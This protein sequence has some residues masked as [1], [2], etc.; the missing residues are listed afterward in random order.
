MKEILSWLLLAAVVSENAAAPAGLLRTRVAE[1]ETSNEELQASFA[2]LQ[3]NNEELQASFGELQASFGE[4]QGSF[5]ALSLQGQSLFIQ[6]YVWQK[7]SI[8]N[9]FGSPE[10]NIRT[11]NGRL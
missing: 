5:I 3:A 10:I 4:L 8:I 6:S 2:E 9:Y 11:T 1:L 7:M